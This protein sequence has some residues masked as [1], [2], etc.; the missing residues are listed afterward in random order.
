MDIGGL[1]GPV[2]WFYLFLRA[3]PQRKRGSRGAAADPVLAQA[4]GS[5]RDPTSPHEPVCVA[6]GTNER[7]LDFGGAAGLSRPTVC[8]R[9]TVANA[10]EPA[11]PNLHLTGGAR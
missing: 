1:R 7:E 11:E 9:G 3:T 4:A 2:V 5:D 6:G 10:G 8:H